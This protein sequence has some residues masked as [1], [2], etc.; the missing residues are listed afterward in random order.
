MKTF[1]SRTKLQSSSQT[2]FLSE[3]KNIKQTLIKNG[4]PNNIVDTEIK[5]FIN[6]IEQHNID[7]MLNHKQSIDLY[8]K[9]QFHSNY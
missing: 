4:F 7:N 5:H 2:I 9:K 8:Y 1:T 6:K 3:L